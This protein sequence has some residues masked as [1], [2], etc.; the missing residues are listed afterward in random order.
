[1]AKK[2]ITTGE[3]GKVTVMLEVT[4]ED[5]KVWG[6]RRGKGEGL[7]GHMVLW[8]CLFSSMRTLKNTFRGARG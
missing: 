8:E 1:M 2:Q 6:A 3:Q 5:R 7:W 4:E